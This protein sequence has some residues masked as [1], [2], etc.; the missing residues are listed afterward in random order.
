MILDN[1]VLLQTGLHIFFVRYFDAGPWHISI[2]NDNNFSQR[3]T[4]K[5]QLQGKSFLLAI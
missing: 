5:T 1:A 4:F 3:V 2:Y